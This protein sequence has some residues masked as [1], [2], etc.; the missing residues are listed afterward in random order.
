MATES[1]TGGRYL[2]KNSELPRFLSTLERIASREDHSPKSEY[3]I[4]YLDNKKRQLG[5]EQ[6]VRAISYTEPNTAADSRLFNDGSWILEQKGRSCSNARSN[7][8]YSVTNLKFSELVALAQGWTEFQGVQLSAPIMPLT[9][10]VSQ[11]QNYFVDGDKRLRI[12][13]DNGTTYYAFV[14]KLIA[15]KIGGEY[16]SRVGLKMYDQS[17]SGHLPMLC[18]LLG[19][20]GAVPVISKKDTANNMH[21]ARL[22]RESGLLKEETDTEIEAKLSISPDRQSLFNTIKTDF[23]FNRVRGFTIKEGFQYTLVNGKISTYLKT[24]DNRYVRVST[25]GRERV[26]TTKED[27]E[28]MNDA[29]GLGCIVKRKELERKPESK[30]IL[31]DGA[32]LYKKT[33]YFIVT[34][35][36]SDRDYHVSIDSCFRI[37]N[38][39]F[40]DEGSLS[41]IEIEATLMNPSKGQETEASKDIANVAK[42]LIDLHDELAPTTVTKQEWLT[43]LGRK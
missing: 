28:T 26:V 11:R 10:A 22:L 36:E 6:T 27:S 17:M 43:N 5:P 38:N 7:E 16:F 19:S 8:L 21:S 12:T 42:Q 30:L 29:Y 35:N 39:W 24:N 1:I 3:V 14:K 32:S 4:A 15:D 34:G 18:A 13:V 2:I 9:A 33:K 23:E 37:N 40:S 41:Q 25:E 20:A 31:S